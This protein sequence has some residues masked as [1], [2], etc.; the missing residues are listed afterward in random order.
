MTN[1]PAVQHKMRRKVKKGDIN[2]ILVELRSD[3]EELSL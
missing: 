3:G 1:Q 2:S